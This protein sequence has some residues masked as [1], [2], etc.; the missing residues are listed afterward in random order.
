[1]KKNAAAKLARRL[2]RLASKH[3]RLVRRCEFAYDAAIR[4]EINA[5]TEKDAWRLAK[6]SGHRL[7]DLQAVRAGQ[8]L[9]EVKLPQTARNRAK[10]GLAVLAA[11]GRVIARALR[12]AAA[13]RKAQVVN[14]AARVARN[15]A[16]LVRAALR[17]AGRTVARRALL[18][19]SLLV[20]VTN[21]QYVENA[22]AGYFTRATLIERCVGGAS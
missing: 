20:V 3:A 10:Q 9:P 17:R 16:R 18:I 6:V 11:I 14:A 13:L 4:A 5:A 22:Y 19:V 1:M 21:V 8:P 2:A 15:T 12:T 7:R